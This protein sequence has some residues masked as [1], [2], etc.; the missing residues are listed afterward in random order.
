MT[1]KR[2]VVVTGVGAV[3]PLA[4]NAKSTWEKL[5]AGKSGIGNI[6]IFDVND[7]PCRI[8]GEV[9]LGLEG[10]LFNID[11]YIDPK[12]QK[13]MDRFI[14]FAVAAAQQ[15]IED[16]GWVAETEEQ[17]YRTGVMIGSGIGGLPSIEKTVLQ[18]K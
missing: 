10:D 5:I 2:R 17:K 16:S 4:E 18:I 14:H 3:T 13:K 1:E 8:A 6:T 11:K 7:S 12:E 15:A 9:K